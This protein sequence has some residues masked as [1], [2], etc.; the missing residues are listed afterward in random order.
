MAK[1]IEQRLRVVFG[2][3]SAGGRMV[4]PCSHHESL[5]HTRRQDLLGIAPSK[6]LSVGD[7]GTG[8]VAVSVP[9]AA[10]AYATTPGWLSDSGMAER[11]RDG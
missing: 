5:E 3:R 9:A 6:S 4:L 1:V 10:A 8:A 11:L 2:A 7:H